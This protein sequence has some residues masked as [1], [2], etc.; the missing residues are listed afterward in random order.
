MDPSQSHILPGA[1]PCGSELLPHM[2]QARSH[3]CMQWVC[4]HTCVLH[5]QY[6]QGCT[7]PQSGMA[8]PSRAWEKAELGG[9]LPSRERGQRRDS[10]GLTG[11][12]GDLISSSFSSWVEERWSCSSV[13]S[14]CGR[15]RTGLGQEEG[16]GPW[17]LCPW[18]GTLCT[19]GPQNPHRPVLAVAA[20]LA[21]ALGRAVT[22]QQAAFSVVRI[23]HCIFLPVCPVVVFYH[24]AKGGRAG[25]IWGSPFPVSHQS[26]WGSPNAATRA[27][28]HSPYHS[29]PRGPWSCPLMSTHGKVPGWR[30]AQGL[31]VAPF[32]AEIPTRLAQGH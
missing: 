30:S 3:Q 15:Q 7:A 27:G 21:V 12:G 9:E 19:A 25:L 20:V 5:Y 24:T 23:L 16:P 18:V 29:I 28:G 14:A 6:M 11:S 32:H 2:D 1:V 4:A 31:P 10:Q 8:C 13:F 26:S 22:L 17:P